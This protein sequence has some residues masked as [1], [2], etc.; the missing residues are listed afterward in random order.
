MKEQELRIK[1]NNAFYITLGLWIFI[2]TLRF[3][4]FDNPVLLSF[5]FPVLSRGLCLLLFVESVYKDGRPDRRRI[6]KIILYLVLGFVSYYFSK[7]T[8]FLDTFLVVGTA[9]KIQLNKYLKTFLYSITAG[10]VVIG[11]LY[12]TRVLPTPR[13]EG[14]LVMGFVGEPQFAYT[15]FAVLMLFT[16]LYWDKYKKFVLIVL[17]SI[18]P[19]F[20][21]Q[22]LNKTASLLVMLFLSML[23]LIWIWQRKK[24]CVLDTMF[25][26]AVGY[27]FLA[28]II[29]ASYALI[30]CS[31]LRD[32]LNPVLFTFYNRFLFGS[33]I[34]KE[35][36]VSLFGKNI[37]FPLY[38]CLNE[39]N[40]G[41]VNMFPDNTFVQLPVVFGI[42]PTLILIYL[43]YAS[44]IK[45]IQKKNEYV[46]AAIICVCMYASMEQIMTQ[47][48]YSFIFIGLLKTEGDRNINQN[49]SEHV[50]SEK[51]VLKA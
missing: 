1:V 43:L 13:F 17:I 21:Y 9:Q 18:I 51:D 26:K 45:F 15:L 27:S 31:K 23:G 46:L 39:P 10:V 20:Y 35:F 14:R 2:S 48:V 30:L 5:I 41:Y 42:I 8:V 6:V 38:K 22:L 19:F 33:V 3:G 7:K 25:G 50:L 29:V 11:I 44:I 24:K 12:F 37:Q 32:P 36:G 40:E 28:L 47:L 49:E 16:I 34:L 4:A